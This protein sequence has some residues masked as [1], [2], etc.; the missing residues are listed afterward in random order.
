ML[1]NLL[2]KHS[3]AILYTDSVGGSDEVEKLIKS[4]RPIARSLDWGYVGGRAVLSVKNYNKKKISKVA[5]Q[6]LA[7]GH[8]LYVNDGSGVTLN[9]GETWDRETI[10]AR[11]IESYDEFVKRDMTKCWHQVCGMDLENVSYWQTKKG[12]QFYEET[13]KPRL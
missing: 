6:I 13:I 4:L 9:V 5:N 8:R 12:Q 1:F 7:Q 10:E 3:F 2:E 11:I